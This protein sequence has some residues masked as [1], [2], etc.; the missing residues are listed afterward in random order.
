MYYTCDQILAE[1]S[2][3]MCIMYMY[4]Y[5]RLYG[6]YYTRLYTTIENK[7]AICTI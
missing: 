2:V 3:Y 1:K 7:L 6:M 4:M 5:M